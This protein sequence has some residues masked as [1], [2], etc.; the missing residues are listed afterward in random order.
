MKQMLLLPTKRQKS[1][2]IQ[3]KRQKTKSLQR[4]RKKLRLNLRS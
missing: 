1:K 3:R 2:K 4:R